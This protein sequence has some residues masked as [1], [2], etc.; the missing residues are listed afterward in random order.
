MILHELYGDGH[1]RERTGHPGVLDIWELGWPLLRSDD[2]IED[3]MWKSDLPAEDVLP[4]SELY[5]PI[6]DTDHC[7][8]VERT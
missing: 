1:M 4:L 8:A 7:G 2:R 5:R 3:V 6:T